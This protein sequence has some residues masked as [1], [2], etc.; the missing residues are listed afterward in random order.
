MDKTSLSLELHVGDDYKAFA[1]G[2]QPIS[3]ENLCVAG[4][5]GV[6]LSGI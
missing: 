4:L 1:L 3:K 6:V 2:F 5:D